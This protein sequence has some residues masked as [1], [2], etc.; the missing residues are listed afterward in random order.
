[1]SHVLLPAVVVLL[2]RSSTQA[3]L[4]SDMSTSLTVIS[5]SMSWGSV[6][7]GTGMG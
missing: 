1:V 4:T 6:S 3:N 5:L 2:G 7:P